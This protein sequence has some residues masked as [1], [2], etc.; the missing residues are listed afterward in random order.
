MHFILIPPLLA[1]LWKG[2]TP[3]LECVMHQSA[4]LT[5]NLIPLQNSAKAQ[6]VLLT[7]FAQLVALELF[8]VTECGNRRPNVQER[9]K[10]RLLIVKFPVCLVC[11]RLFPLR[12][13]THIHD[14]HARHHHNHGVEHFALR[15]LDEHSTEAWIERK[16]GKLAANVGK[17][18]LFLHRLDLLERAMPLTDGTRRGR[19]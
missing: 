5:D 16:P 2:C 10:V 7:E 19:A 4:Q 3:D 15:G 8:L 1:I 18:A 11:L 17:I 13:F 6:E 12:P 14:T 9:Q